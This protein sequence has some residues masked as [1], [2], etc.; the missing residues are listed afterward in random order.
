MTTECWLWSFIC[1][2]TFQVVAKALLCKTPYGQWGEFRGSQATAEQNDIVHQGMW[3]WVSTNM[4]PNLAWK[5]GKS[6]DRWDTRAKEPEEG[7]ALRIRSGLGVLRV[8]DKE[9]LAR[10]QPF[11]A[12][13]DPWKEYLKMWKEVR[14]RWHL[15]SEKKDL[16]CRLGPQLQAPN[17]GGYP[18][19]ILGP[20]PVNLP[21][22]IVLLPVLST[23]S[24][25]GQLV[26]IS[27]WDLTS[28]PTEA[29]LTYPGWP[30]WHLLCLTASVLTSTRQHVCL[31]H[32]MVSSLKARS[33][34][35]Q[36]SPQSLA[37]GRLWM[38]IESMD[39]GEE[40]MWAGETAKSLEGIK[41]KEYCRTVRWAF[42]VK[43]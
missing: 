14:S 28:P 21:T 40:A 8:R 23:L 15:C 12:G 20:R 18:Y 34:H 10:Y 36:H 31:L 43:D 4:G 7:L 29:I 33:L 41:M 22:I 38:F 25:P 2:F 1:S 39:C 27:E 5:P 19:C 35:P 9:T 26:C 6:F 3:G 11:L 32:Q 30:G 17:P 42:E 24:P 13:L 16:K 37:C